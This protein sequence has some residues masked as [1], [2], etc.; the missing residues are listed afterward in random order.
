M[1]KIIFLLFCCMCFLPFLTPSI[2]SKRNN[3]II[4]FLKHHLD[5]RTQRFIIPPSKKVVGALLCEKEIPCFVSAIVLHL[6]SGCM[7]SKVLYV[8]WLSEN[9]SVKK[10]D[11]FDA[12]DNLI[13]TLKIPPIAYRFG[14]RNRIVCDYTFNDNDWKG[15]DEFDQQTQ[16][17]AQLA[18]STRRVANRIAL[19]L[20]DI[21]PHEN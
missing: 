11:I 14:D 4:D 13:N 7:S 6:P 18:T 2:E 15:L 1:K 16:W 12:N 21:R 8:Y 5:G 3:S 10:I 9:D 19:E 17:T 20:I